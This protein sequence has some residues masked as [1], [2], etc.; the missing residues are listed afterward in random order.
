MST[1][2][3]DCDRHQAVDAPVRVTF[4]D[5][6]AA[7]YRIR[8]GIKKTPCEK[9]KLS[10]MVKMELYFKK[11]YLHI[12]GSFKERGA[13]NTLLLLSKEQKKKGVIAASAG[14]H[15]LALS[16]HGKVLGIPVTVVMPRNAP[17]MK[18]S[19]CKKYQ[20]TVIVNGAD[21]IEYQATVIVN[22]ADIIEVC[23]K[24][25][26]TVIVNG[27]DI[28]EAKDI[29]L[30]LAKTNGQEYI[31]GY[32]HPHI[33][34][35]QGTCGLEIIDDVPDA[36]A[37]VIPIG[38]GGLIA[39]MSV[40]IKNLNP[41]ITIIGVESEHCAS[42]QAAMQAG[43]PVKIEANQAMTLADG[44]CVTKVGDNAFATAKPYVDKVISVREDF[45]ALAILRLIEEE[46][47][48]VEGA[49]VTA[50]AAIVAGLLPELEGKKVVV[51]LCGGNI[52]S[53]VL[54]RCIDRGLAADGRLVRFIVTVTDRPGG[55]A[56]LTR[57]LSSLEASVKDI[58]H[59]RAW[60]TSSVF[61]VQI[62]TVAEVR[63][64]EHGLEVKQAL[65]LHYPDSVM[66]GEDQR[67]Q[68]TSKP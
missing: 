38:G 40:A 10:D 5:I 57:L 50:F 6:S 4:E 31:N 46:K 26:A 56:E 33:L 23:K 37:V 61:S 48:V 63:D 44:L 27:A 36:D 67:Y 51:P 53:T 21:I 64:Q 2:G 59:E 65:E 19:A 22:G 20:A 34:A 39:G 47:A 13:R 68:S 16:Y 9:S 58:Y 7:A 12:T 62:K 1:I 17:I 15:A 8:K 3:E 54:G 18:I 11:E 24:Y 32:D 66:W 14:N 52:D 30:R 55:I 25:Q 49:G 60:L 35:G 41:D 45:I 28:I 43:H 42:F 29:A